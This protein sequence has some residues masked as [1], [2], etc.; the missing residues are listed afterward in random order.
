MIDN[1]SHKVPAYRSKIS[2]KTFDILKDKI[3][4]VLVVGKKYKEH[5]FSAKKLAEELGTNTRYVSLVLSVRYHANYSAFVNRLRIEEAMAMLLDRRYASLKIEEISDI[6]GFANRQS[7]YRAF[8]L[9]NKMT[10]RA[11]Q[12]KYMPDDSK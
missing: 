6:V 12:E 2:S 3:I 8:C 9:I 7:F 10:P 1:N 4:N 5:D 11:Y